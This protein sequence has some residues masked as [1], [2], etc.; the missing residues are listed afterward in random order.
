MS[1]EALSA[2]ASHRSDDGPQKL[3]LHVEKLTIA[4]LGTDAGL[5]AP[6]S[7]GSERARLNR[8]P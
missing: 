7:A 8:D 6:V 1:A 4:D 5:P 2:A 3:G